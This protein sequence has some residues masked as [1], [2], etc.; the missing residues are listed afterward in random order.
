M[1]GEEIM[2]LVIIAAEPTE[3][4]VVNIQGRIDMDKLAALEG[5]FGVPEITTEK[6][7]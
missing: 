1:R 2:G 7:P 4:T 3:F 6:R 5:H